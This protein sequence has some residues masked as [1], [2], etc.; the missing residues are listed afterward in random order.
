MRAVKA[1]IAV[2]LASAAPALGMI[3][4]TAR[5]VPTVYVTGNS[6]PIAAERRC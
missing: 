2:A 6:A 3:Q 4:A 1:T 5:D